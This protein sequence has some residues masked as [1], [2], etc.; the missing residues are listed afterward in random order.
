M[1]NGPTELYIE[2]QVVSAL[3]EMFADV[4]YNGASLELDDFARQLISALDD[5]GIDLV[6]R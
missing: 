4:G 2:R 6:P 1:A 3:T 5:R